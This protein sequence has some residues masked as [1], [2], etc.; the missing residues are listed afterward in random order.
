MREDVASLNVEVQ[1]NLT[2]FDWYLGA[3]LGPVIEDRDM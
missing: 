2:L 1:E 3:D